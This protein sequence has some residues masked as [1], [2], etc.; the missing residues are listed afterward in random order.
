MQELYTTFQLV[1]SLMHMISHFFTG[2]LTY[3]A[4][5]NYTSGVGIIILV[6]LI[7]DLL[8]GLPFDIF[9]A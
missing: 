1:F 5:T 2:F 3:Y 6:Y 8:I 4:Y 7:G 9:L